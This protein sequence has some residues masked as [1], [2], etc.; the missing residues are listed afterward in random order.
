MGQ[1]I[2]FAIVRHLRA[3]WRILVH[4]LASRFINNGRDKEWNLW[5]GTASWKAVEELLDMQEV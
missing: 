4:L 3:N 5:N 2:T 1:S